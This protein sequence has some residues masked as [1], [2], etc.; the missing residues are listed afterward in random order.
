MKSKKEFLCLYESKHQNKI[1]RLLHFIGTMQLFIAIVCTT[2]LPEIWWILIPSVI[3]AY[4][5]PH[6]GHRYFEKNRSMRNDYPIGCVY[7][8]ARMFF[9]TMLGRKES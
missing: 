8:S 1:N 7:G 6:F 5:L 4:L 2:C 9:R 3:L